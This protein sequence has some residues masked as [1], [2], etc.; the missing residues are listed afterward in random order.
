VWP[1]ELVGRAA[2]AAPVA[3]V[4]KSVLGDDD[5]TATATASA[6]VATHAAVATG[7]AAHTAKLSPKEIFARAAPSVVVIDVEAGIDDKSPLAPFA[8]AMGLDSVHELGSG[9]FVGPNLVVTNDHVAGSARSMRVRS[10]EN[11]TVSLVRVLALDPRND[12]ALLEVVLPVS[13]LALGPNADVGDDAVAIGAPLGLD[14]TLTS[15]LV[16]QRRTLDG[17][18]F[19][20]V[21][22]T[23]APGSS[24]GPLLDDH[25][26][27]IGVNT[28]TRGAGL[29]LAVD[30]AHVQALLQMP[31]EP[32]ALSR[33]A[34]DG[35][36]LTSLEI[37]GPQPLPTQRAAIASAMALYGGAVAS[38]VP[39]GDAE[40]SFDADG[41]VRGLEGDQ[42]E[43]V[44]KKTARLGPAFGEPITARFVVPTARHLVIHVRERT[45]ASP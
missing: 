9:F 45:N 30:V 4:M 7:A 20:Q 22:T 19:L 25:A 16:S 31:R 39:S 15:G 2:A 8:K 29:N 14:Y 24:G 43:C 38:C 40:V 28:A 12:L 32:K 34:D 41:A 18:H 13:P 27:V 36:A 23:I 35:V 3:R 11:G 21:Q 42:Q 44:A 26:R 10:K 1:A 17:T 5:A 33:Y 6:T 37:A